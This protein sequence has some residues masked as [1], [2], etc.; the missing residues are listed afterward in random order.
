MKKIIFTF[1]IFLALGSLC[2]SKEINAY[3]FN[4]NHEEKVI[5]VNDVISID[6]YIDLDY[7]EDALGY[8][9]EL[10]G[11]VLVNYQELLFQVDGENEF[12]M[13]ELLID[14]GDGY[15]EFTVYTYTLNDLVFINNVSEDT[16]WYKAYSY[17]YQEGLITETEF[18]D[19]YHKFTERYSKVNQSTNIGNE[20]II[21]TENEVSPAVEIIADYTTFT[22]TLYFEFDSSL[23]ETH[24]VVPLR[25][26]KIE[27]I[28]DN[29]SASETVGTSY[30]DSNGNF[31]VSLRNEDIPY[32][33]TY[34]VRAYAESY[35]FRILGYSAQSYTVD[36]HTASYTQNANIT[37]SDT[38]LFNEDSWV[39]KA[40]S[41]QQMME[42]GERYAL[43]KDMYYSQKMNVLYPFLPD[44]GSFTYD[45]FC[46]IDYD[47]YNYFELVVHEYGHFVQHRFNCYDL[48]FFELM[49][50]D[51]VHYEN[52][53]LFSKKEDK[54]Y[55]MKLVWSESW[56]SVFTNVVQDYYLDDYSYFF[57]CVYDGEDMDL[58][59]KDDTITGFAK[60]FKSYNL[61]SLASLD[62]GDFGEG[63]ELAVMAFLYD[64]YDAST[65][66]VFDNI[67]LG[68]SIWWNLTMQEEVN[69]LS[70]FLESCY[71]NATYYKKMSDFGAILEEYH[72]SPSNL[73]ISNKS[74]VSNTVP[75]TLSWT[76]EG[77]SSHPNNRF[78]IAVYRSDSNFTSSDLLY[79]ISNINLSGSINRDN[80]YTYSISSSQWNTIL[81]NF[82]GLTNASIHFVVKGY[83][84]TSVISGP[85]NSS[86][87]SI[88]ISIPHTHS[89]TYSYIPKSNSK[90][91][92]MCSCGSSKT[93]NCIGILGPNDIRICGKCKQTLSGGI[94][95]NDTSENDE[96]ILFFREEE[97]F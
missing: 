22:G 39:T 53:D 35:T 3:S 94:I 31:S 10:E 40:F 11:I 19:L 70:S 63:Q 91:T 8:N 78:D 80:T 67:A 96:I 88:S 61:E 54:D 25:N 41:V 58:V 18:N 4:E 48:S 38:I 76:I 51:P 89:Y 2:K 82:S 97:T 65:D 16:V 32:T 50:N 64:L 17:I 29:G 52:Q 73:E 30:T 93:E 42:L 34:K 23:R 75:P 90:H 21:L 55:A 14:F 95:L 59:R 5:I 77:S 69:T 9:Y 92:A 45:Y 68:E 62:E 79:T 37:Y 28:V 43:S 56:A 15:E 1:F 7:L 49:R 24:D 83:N 66:E 46:F 44:M 33:S 13:I 36:L 74:S 57:G 47:W 84:T 27:V 85:Y 12:G 60:M 71:N 26:T 72:I 6:D 87:E 81:N 20:E 86:F